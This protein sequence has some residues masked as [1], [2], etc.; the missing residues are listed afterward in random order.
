M[1]TTSRWLVA[2]LL[3][4]V[5]MMGAGPSALASPPA[6]DDFVNADVVSSLPFT[7]SGDLSGLTSEPGEP[8]GCLFGPSPTAWYVVTP[9]ASGH[10]LVDPSESSFTVNTVGWESFGGGFGGLGLL[11]CGGGFSATPM[12]LPVT[13]GSTYFVQVGLFGPG[14]S[15]FQLRIDM[16]TAPPNDDFVDATPLSGVPVSA[17]VDLTAAT[18]ETGEPEAA[19]LTASAWYAYSP[20]SDATLLVRPGFDPAN[21]VAV[22]SGSSL[23]DLT[24][25]ARGSGF[26]SPATFPAQGG[27]TY[28]VQV[29]KAASF[30]GF[31]Q[32]VTITIE[33]PGPPIANFFAFPFEPSV[34][35]NLQFFDSSF[36]PAFIGFGPARWDFGDGATATGCCPTHRFAADAD[37]TVTMVATTLDGR[38][39]TASQIISV[40]THDVS[41]ERFQAPNSARVGQSKDV[42]VNVR[43]GRYAETVQVELYKSVAGGFEQYIGAQSLPV[44][45]AHGGQTTGFDFGYTFTADDAAAGKV[46]FPG[47][48]HHQR[49]PRRPARRQPGHRPAHRSQAVIQR[50]VSRRQE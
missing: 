6:N 42:R 27:T 47:H 15:S 40:R 41:I 31:S 2:T 1:R 22:Y 5:L 4:G 50:P 11:G 29:A 13:A 26:S 38:T 35:D 23:A 25:L 45:V 28:Y 24:L 32:V 21:V 18:I 8:S 36:D 10:L 12:V 17:T 39:A 9:A 46:T 37:Y 19:G 48:R 44:P 16:V 30:P 20:V 33:Q 3:A 43:G 34:H 7:D 14:P 49:R